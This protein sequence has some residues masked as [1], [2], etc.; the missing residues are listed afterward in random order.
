MNVETPR[1]ILRRPRLADV[2]ALFEFLGDAEAMRHTC[3]DAPYEN[4]AARV[5]PSP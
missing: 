4:A 1:L 5:A 2:P 3:A